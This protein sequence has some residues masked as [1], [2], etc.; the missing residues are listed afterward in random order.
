[1]SRLIQAFADAVV[2]RR[3]S[4]IAI[5]AILTVIFAVFATRAD[6]RTI[7]GDM[8]PQNH[9]WVETNEAYKNEFGGPNLVSIMVKADQ[10]TIFQEPILKM[11]QKITLDL[12]TVQGANE[13]Q[14]TSLASRK[15]K[16][17]KATD[18]L[19]ETVP[20][21]WPD[22]PKTPAEISSLRTR[23][24]QTPLVY[25]RY[26]SSDLKS[27]LITVNFLDQLVVPQAIFK[28]VNKIIEDNRIPG[29]TTYVVGE[30]ILY[31]WVR[32]YLPQTLI[33]SL[34]TILVLAVTLFLLARTWRG[35]LLPLVAG[36]VSACWALGIGELLGLN[37]DP[38]VV[39]VAFLITARSISHSVQMV[40]RFDDI[41]AA[42]PKL[43]IVNA[44]SE[45]LRELFRPGVLG[46][47]A[48]AGAIL[49]VLLTPIPFLQ[50]VSIIG[51]IWVGTILFSAVVLTPTLLA[52]MR[53]VGRPAHPINLYPMMFRVLDGCVWVATT[54]ARYV[55]IG[56]AVLLFLGAGAFA[57]DLQV[58]D[59]KPGSPILA[60]HS[61]Y[62]QGAEAISKNFAGSDHLFV[63]FEGD[64]PDAMKDMDVLH[65]MHR[66]QRYMAGDPN[67]GGSASLVDVISSMNEGMHEG[68]PRYYSLG[69]NKRANGQYLYMYL[70]G[71]DPGDLEEFS[72]RTYKNGA[73]TLFFHNHTG[74]TIRTAFAEIEEFI[75]SN[76][77]T[78]ATYRLAGG[79]VAVLGAV[80]D[81]ILEGQIEAIA[82]GLLVVVLCSMIAYRSTTAGMFFMLPVMLSNMVT[83]AY[84]S[85]NG[86]GLN[87]DTLP[88]VS[89]GIGL[90]VDYSFYI[91]D[92]IKE[93]LAA[94]ASGHDAIAK[95]LHSAGRG[96]FITA[97][98]LVGSVCL[99]MLSSLRFQS[100]M[101]ILIAVWLAVSATTA[102]YILPGLAYITR[103]KFIFGDKRHDMRATV[104]TSPDH[105][106]GQY[107]VN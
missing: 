30:P 64:K 90:G 20:L 53:K 62:N 9:P 72:D 21:M 66:F 99:W 87:L 88:I 49:V 63:V 97:A 5:L 82:L 54:R 27:A 40:T 33:I 7:F 34:L 38:L 25:G 23:V 39:V 74:E 37:F 69:K 68:N 12:R 102:L 18:A 106:L 52:C 107:E 79:L 2:H 24:L 50:K 44:A 51:A 104:V 75:K 60:E 6:V 100:N 3:L 42:K 61:E 32:Y 26:V 96:V 73:V 93:E 71:S 31:G 13:F 77:M 16:T 28:Q 29:V 11:I 105:A 95:S 84:M 101:G 92:G 19:I 94:G 47:V 70:S 81:V 67:V 76:P 91:V 59:A 98:T 17:V 35:T 78:H 57:M 41:V 15:L 1:M 65:T 46:V 83:F 58:G 55:A 85:I 4:V 103:P 56:L 8:L 10:G 22:V 80:N 36:V 43:S 14:I 89:L 48:D 45:S 86:I